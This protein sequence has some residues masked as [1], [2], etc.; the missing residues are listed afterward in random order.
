M[1]DET[2]FQHTVLTATAH[3]AQNS[4]PSDTNTRPQPYTPRT[5]TNKP[6]RMMEG[7]TDNKRWSAVVVPKALEF[8]GV[9][10]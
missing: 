3:R 8:G 5:T 2:H 4:R 7:S 1:R 10:L 9:T 6:T